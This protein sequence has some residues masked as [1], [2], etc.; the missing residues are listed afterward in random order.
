MLAERAG[1]RERVGNG[2]LKASRKL[3]GG[4]KSDRQH[5]LA[6]AFILRD[7]HSSL[8]KPS[9]SSG[10]CAVMNND[11][12]IR[13]VFGPHRAQPLRVAATAEEVRLRAALARFTDTSL[14]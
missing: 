8:L 10:D 1:N 11:E 7:T 3:V 5:F 14:S 4:V 6:R 9:C 13:I 12:I 2:F